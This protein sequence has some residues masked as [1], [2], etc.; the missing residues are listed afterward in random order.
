MPE[1]L[2]LTWSTLLYLLAFL[3][4]GAGY[5]GCVLPYPGM[6]FVLAGLICANVANG[7][8]ETP[9]WVWTVLVLLTVAGLLADNVTTMLGAKKFGSSKAA[10]WAAVLGLFIGA[11]FFPLGIVVGPFVAALLAEIIIARK[12]SY[13]AAQSGIG[14][15][16]GCLAGMMA[17][18]IIA[19]LM[20]LFY[21]F[22]A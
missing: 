1:A 18:I 17:K 13:D 19:T 15:V 8:A 20:V 2:S 3:L 6:L 12:N 22:A 16:L 11:F 14:A 4:V 10:V 21:W 9:C 5:V 7:H